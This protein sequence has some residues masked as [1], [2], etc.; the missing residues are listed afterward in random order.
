MSNTSTLLRQEGRHILQL[1]GPILVAQFAQTANGFVDTVMAGDVSP[2]D[3]AAVAVGSAIWIP[4]FLFLVGV[5]QGLTPFV[6]QFRG[7]ADH[8]AIG[9]VVQQGLWLALPLGL[10]GFFSL[11]AMAPVLALMEV[12]VGIR[13]LILGYLDGLSWGIPAITLFLALRSLTEGMSYTA[14][15]MV[16]SLLGLAVNVPVNYVLIH[17]ELG[18]PALGGVGCGWATSVVMWV[19]LILMAGYALGFDRRHQTGLFQHRA[20][21]LLRHLLPILRVGLPIGLAIFIEVSLFCVIALFI[22]GIGAEVV[23]GHQVALNAASMAFMVPL[24]LSLALTVRVG[25]HVG[26]DQPQALRHAV[27]AGLAII[28]VTA[29]VNSALMA[30]LRHPIA[31][32]YTDDPV[33]IELA[34][35]LLLFA[36]LFQLSDCLQVGANGV[37]RGMKDT[38]WP[39]LIT[40]LAYWGLGLPVG[41]LLGLTHWL[42][43][44]LAA[45]GFWIGLLVGLTAAAIMLCWRVQWQLRRPLATA[46]G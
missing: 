45:R 36:A 13:P 40:V 15:V 35:G 30:W 2:E 29:L 37:L 9:V 8:S 44:P 4:V 3:L 21:P 10:L 32:I 42:G 43:P 33:V 19:M 23:A 16:V 5:M 28:L 11:R 1:A 22:A 24:S 31:A 12:D 14:P 25:T 6:A 46:S 20:P 7:R 41:Y 39:M 18:F 27:L 38:R 17:G 34:A 26:R